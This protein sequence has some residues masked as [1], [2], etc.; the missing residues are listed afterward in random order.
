MTTMKSII[1]SNPA[2]L[3]ETD[4]ILFLKKVSSDS[5]QT[6]QQ[7]DQNQDCWK[8][9]ELRLLEIF[10]FAKS[11]FRRY[12]YHEIK[13]CQN[14]MRRWILD[15]KL[16]P[17]TFFIIKCWISTFSI[18]VVKITNQNDTISKNIMSISVLDA[19]ERHS[20]IQAIIQ[21]YDL[22]ID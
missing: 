20:F 12:E 22:F 1:K 18:S 21:N 6:H 15:I 8:Y 14:Y 13:D 5:T 7:H 16:D 10:N 2:E 17:N 4:D 3:V 19:L 11:T 9:V